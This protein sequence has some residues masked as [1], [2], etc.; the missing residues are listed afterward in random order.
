MLILASVPDNDFVLVLCRDVDLQLE[1]SF[2]QL[3]PVC[4]TA[5]V[6]VDTAAPSTIT[7]LSTGDVMQGLAGKVKCWP[8][9]D[10]APSVE[11]PCTT[12]QRAECAQ[13]AD[14]VDARLVD[15]YC[16]HQSPNRRELDT[17]IMQASRL[18]WREEYGKKAEAAVA[19]Q[20]AETGVANEESIRAAVYKSM[21][22]E[23]RVCS[24]DSCAG[25]YCILSHVFVLWLQME[26][27]LRAELSVA[28]RVSKLRKCTRCWNGV[29]T[30]R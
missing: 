12:C 23:V 16:N 8:L 20:C 3:T 1:G 22:S 13:C 14:A 27:T 28:R 2:L 4:H 19:A 25:C 29:L 24:C 21:E 30:H 17:A 5:T 7:Y 9:R 26:A 10:Y 11:L 6:I 18:R 15:P